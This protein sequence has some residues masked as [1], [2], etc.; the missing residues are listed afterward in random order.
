MKKVSPL[1]LFRVITISFLTLSFITFYTAE[2]DFISLIGMLMTGTMFAAYIAS[3]VV[4]ALV[5]EEE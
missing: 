2:V 4:M 3:E 5:K 1:T